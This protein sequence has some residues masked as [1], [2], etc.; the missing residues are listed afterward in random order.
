MDIYLQ[1]WASIANIVISKEYKKSFLQ[2]EEIQPLDEDD[3]YCNDLTDCDLSRCVLYKSNC[4]SKNRVKR[5]EEGQ[6]FA[7]DD[8]FEII[9]NQKYT[10]IIYVYCVLSKK[11]G[12]I[13]VLWS[14]GCPLNSDDITSLDLSNLIHFLNQLYTS[15]N[16]IQFV[17]CG[18]SMG[19]VLAENLA[20]EIS[21]EDEDLCDNISIVGSAPFSWM[22]EEILEKLHETYSNRIFIFLV[23]Y[24]KHGKIYIDPMFFRNIDEEEE[25]DEGDE[26]EY[27]EEQDVRYDINQYYPINVLLFSMRDNSYTNAITLLDNSNVEK[28]EMSYKNDP[29][30]RHNVCKNHEWK[31]YLPLIKEYIANISTRALSPTRS[32]SPR[33]RSRSPSSRSPS[34]KSPDS[35]VSQTKKQK[36][37][38][39]TRKNLKNIQKNNWYF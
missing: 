37:G 15:N 14:S 4:K 28:F 24:E 8:L 29:N 31:F 35:N 30:W 16:N 1:E 36:N 7:S 26:Y 25:E 32:T 23:G 21:I 34:S 5:F 9:Y 6:I 3:R 17:F 20:Y 22:S 33:T 2:R 10:Y 39:K 12:N 27:V 11:T 38:G 13:Y 19:C 18:H